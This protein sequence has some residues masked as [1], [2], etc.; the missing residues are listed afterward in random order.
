[1]SQ[2]TQDDEAS[3]LT[4]IAGGDGAAFGVLYRRYLPVVLR[5]CLRETGNREVAADL[6][7]EVFAAALTS[8]HRYRGAQGSVLAWLLGIARNKLLESLRRSRVADSA[9]RGL[10][11]EPMLLTDPDLERVDELTSLDESLMARVQELPA[12]LRDALTGRVIDERPYE[13]IA[14]EL[15]CSESVVRQRVS[16]ALRTLRSQLE[17]R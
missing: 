14:S 4:A 8:A 10:R 17:E 16:R 11:L 7:A 13:Q 5:W 15:R 9:R 6:S 1:M 2:W 3:L 12:A